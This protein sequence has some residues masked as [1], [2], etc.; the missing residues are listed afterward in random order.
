MKARIRVLTGLAVLLFSSFCSAN[1]ISITGNL[2]DPNGF[3]LHNF[4]IL[5]DGSDIVIQSWSFAGG[6]NAASEVIPAGGFILDLSLFDPAGV[7]IADSNFLYSCP[8]ANIDPDF[9]CGDVTL[10]LSNLFAGEYTLGI[11][12]APNFPVGN[13]ADGFCASMNPANGCDGTFVGN[14]GEQRSSFYAVDVS[15]NSPV[16]EVPEPA[17]LTFLASSCLLLRRRKRQTS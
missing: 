17:T 11:V 10:S 4:S 6:T 12:A 8:P 5:N 2:G 3:A 7:L 14:F 15:V 16:S 9:G 13:L 1:V